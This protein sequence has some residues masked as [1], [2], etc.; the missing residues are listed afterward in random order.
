MFLEQ[1]M[2]N[3]IIMFKNWTKAENEYRSHIF[4]QAAENWKQNAKVLKSLGQPL[5]P[6]PAV[7]MMVQFDEEKAKIREFEFDNGMAPSVDPF[8]YKPLE[9]PADL[10]EFEGPAAP[11]P[12][13]GSPIGEETAPGS[14]MFY[15]APGDN[16]PV[17]TEIE[18]NGAT[19]IKRAKASPFGPVILWRKL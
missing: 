5:P 17:G 4:F 7:P 10:F 14:G 6:K 1:K 18:V 9:F 8:S 11:A 13:V 19:F 3:T 16:N 12:S 2:A 15:M